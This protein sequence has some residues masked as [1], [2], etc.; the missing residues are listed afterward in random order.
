MKRFVIGNWKQN[1]ITSKKA[2]TLL[3][4]IKKEAGLAKKVETVL[5]PPAVFLPVIK[6]ELKASK[7]ITL[8]GQDIYWEE[9]GAFTGRIGAG[10]LKDSGAKYV[11]VGHSEQRAMGDTDEIVNKKLRAA[12]KAGLS[13]ILCVGEGKRDTNGDFVRFVRDQIAAALKGVQPKQ[14]SSVMVAYEPIWAI[15]TGKAASDKDALEMALLVRHTLIQLYSQKTVGGIP[16]LY[17]GSVK[18]KNCDAF[19][20]HDEIA[21]FLIGGA[22]LIAKEF[23]QIIQ[24]TNART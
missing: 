15:G 7:R 12:I 13:P 5:I 22:S 11:I 4:G 23:S 2:I 9:S 18:A 19:L 21:G 16:V 24:T 8:G 14:I 1:P 17:G 6:K 3:K 10:M 20:Q